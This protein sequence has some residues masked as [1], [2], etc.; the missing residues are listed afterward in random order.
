[1]SEECSHNCS[2]C[3]SKKNGTCGQDEATIAI[4]QQLA[5]IKNKIV[6]LSG[7]GGVGKST[8]AVN[9]A[10]SLAMEG[11]RV[12]LLDV[13]LHGPSIPTMLNLRNVELKGINGKILPVSVAGMSVISVAFF[14]Q[15]ADAPRHLARS[16]EERSHPAIHQRRRMGANWTTW[17]STARP[18]PATKRSESAS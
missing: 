12:G 14:L 17:S 9:L 18:E 11:N 2:T 16:D 5:I 7:K 13:D 6:V 4:S 15:E 3:A 8:C 10:I 1:M